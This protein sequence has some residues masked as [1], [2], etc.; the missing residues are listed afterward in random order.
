LRQAFVEVL[1]V[2][3]DI[4]WSS[5]KYRGI[6]EWDSVAHMQLVAEIEDAFNIMIDTQDVIDMSS[7]EVTKTILAKYGVAFD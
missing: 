3:Q 4:E 7:Y 5:L 2:P 1:G 6:E